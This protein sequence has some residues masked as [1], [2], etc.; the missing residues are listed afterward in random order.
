MV[1]FS[2]GCR[3]AA[4]LGAVLAAASCREARA[5]LY[6]AGIPDLADDLRQDDLDDWGALLRPSAEELRFARVPWLPS[7]PE[8][9]A[10]AAAQGKPVLLWVMNGH[11]LGCT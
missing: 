4:A 1:G 7:V 2:G 9:L 10:A 3:T 5:P 8:G 11:P 6:P